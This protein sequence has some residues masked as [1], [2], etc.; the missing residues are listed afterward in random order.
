[1]LGKTHI[2]GGIMA[3]STTILY[4]QNQVPAFTTLQSGIVIGTSYIMF[5]ALGALLA[6]IDE[7]NSKIGRRLWFISWPIFFLQLVCK[8]PALF[9]IKL[10]KKVSNAVDHRGFTHYPITWFVFSCMAAVFIFQLFTLGYNSSTYNLMISPIVGTCI[11]YLSHL[12]LD[13]FSG[14]LRLLAPFSD[15]RFGIPV[16]K[17]GGLLELVIW[18]GLYIGSF[19]IL[20]IYWYNIVT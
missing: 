18:A 12:I 4:L 9:G 15:K 10:F 2:A 6:D 8:I 1:M 20:R 16:V 11:G 5:S 17:Q 3:G 13:F 14:Y 7:K 19:Y